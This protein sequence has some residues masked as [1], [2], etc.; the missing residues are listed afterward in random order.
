MALLE[1]LQKDMVEAMK[2]KQAPRLDAIRMIKAALQK[3]Q[4]DSMKPLDEATEMQV[5]NTLLKQRKEA[6]E[7][8]TTAGRLDLAEKEA[9][10]QKLV[11]GYMP[12][13]ASDEDIDEAV[14]A[15]IADNPGATAK[16]MGIVMKAAQA[17]LTG[18]RVDGKALSEKVRGKLS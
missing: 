12:G 10:E 11:E 8:Y 13:L 3:F 18:K 9:A 1:K 15:A 17:K 6:V 14:N 4:I 7:M 5:L 2:A 16:Q